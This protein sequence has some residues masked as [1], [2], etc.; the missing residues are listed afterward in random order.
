MRS[1]WHIWLIFVVGLAV[2]LGAM[3]WIS[4]EALRLERSEAEMRRAAA[5]EEDVRLALWRIDSALGPSIARENTRPWFVY[6][7]FYR[8]RGVYQRNA[9]ETEQGDVLVPSPLL[10]SEY[11]NI[12]LFFQFAPDGALTS[13]Q[14]PTG[15]ERTLAENANV[16][17]E[18]IDRA[19]DQLAAF[20]ALVSHDALLRTLNEA[21]EPEAPVYMENADASFERRQ[22]R[23]ACPAAPRAPRAFPVA[24]DA[25]VVSLVV[26]Q[27]S[28][29]TDIEPRFSTSA[30]D[31][32]NE[33][34]FQARNRGQ[35][36]IPAANAGLMNLYQASGP[37]P[38]STA[39]RAVWIGDALLLART[40]RTNSGV[41][42]Q[43]CWLD[44]PSLRDALLD[45]V[46]DLLPNASLEPAPSAKEPG[47][48]LAALPVRIVP[49]NDPQNT[50]L[51][52]LPIRL[53]LTIAWAC[54]VLGAAAVA[55]LLIGAV[56]LSERR[57]AFVSAVTHELRTPLTTFCI[58]TDLLAHGERHGERQNEEKRR[59]YVETLSAEADRL[60]H[61]VENVL[62]YARLTGR[63]GKR[64][65]EVV[66]VEHLLERISDRLSD[67]AARAGMEL[68]VEARAGSDDDAVRSTTIRADET[69]VEQILL[70]L[71]DN[72]CKYAASA[73]DRRIHLDARRT[74]G[75]VL[76]SLRDHGPGIG[77]DVR[78]RLFRP[79][80]KS[81]VEAAHSA[82]GIGLG[83][84]LSRRLAR[85]MGGDLR[86]DDT[87]DD[88][89]CFVLRL[90]IIA[91]ARPPQPGPPPQ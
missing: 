88:G 74:D 43:G 83:L 2:V 89:A 45:E 48:T 38:P 14:V 15:E 33:S 39:L 78:R 41:Y 49:G 21:P 34:E 75:A 12:L 4:R 25:A 54:V 59:Q 31:S 81:A 58:Y 28:T 68:V 64:T 23:A 18:Q 3:A 84:T 67:R 69:V 27:S 65:T 60:S 51:L 72:A 37:M 52:R 85:D 30:Q 24:L 82:A 20:G 56:R 55:V 50:T 87:V 36:L 86:L 19:A 66:S 73:G 10:I 35:T 80:A 76:L 8:T 42:T 79:F 16:T 63:P 62:A 1:S 70:N 7:A 32:F 9:A 11:P 17:A 71:V 47:R 22:P 26:A 46:R 91:G 6:S 29:E 61:L 5:L 90:L 53:T 40:V 57:G 13:P 44:W 77:H